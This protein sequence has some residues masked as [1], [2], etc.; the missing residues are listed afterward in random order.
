M[1]P[2][3]VKQ[4][5]EKDQGPGTRLVLKGLKHALPSI[6]ERNEQDLR[7][8]EPV[9]RNGSGEGLLLTFLSHQE[10]RLSEY[11]KM[12]TPYTTRKT[13]ASNFQTRK[14]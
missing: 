1:L 13:Q 2:D 3:E 8:R 12:L 14:S 5:S 6:A 11:P 9:P 10:H 7:K 4:R